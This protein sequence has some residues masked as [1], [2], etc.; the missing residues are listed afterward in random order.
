VEVAD[1]KQMFLKEKNSVLGENQA[2]GSENK[3]YGHGL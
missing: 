2:L 3:M 1:K